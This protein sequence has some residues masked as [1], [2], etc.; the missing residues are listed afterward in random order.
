M[1]LPSF[2]AITLR[3][4]VKNNLSWLPGGFAQKYWAISIKLSASHLGEEIWHLKRRGEWHRNDNLKSNFPSSSSC[5]LR[6]IKAILQ[7][8]KGDWWRMKLVSFQKKAHSTNLLTRFSW[9][10]TR[11]STQGGACSKRTSLCNMSYNHIGKPRVA[12]NLPK[13][14]HTT[15]PLCSLHWPPVAA[16]ILHLG[17]G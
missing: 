17:R 8:R 16:R 11:N 2:T 9:L 13:F 1:C 4:Q 12:S 6:K 14:S 10:F 5:C 7:I 15:Q 3:T